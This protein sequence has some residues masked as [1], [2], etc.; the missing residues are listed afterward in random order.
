MLAPCFFAL[1]KRSQK[2]QINLCF[3]WRHPECLTWNQ[4]SRCWIYITKS[5]LQL[6]LC[7]CMTRDERSIQT[8][9][10][11]WVPSIKPNI[12]PEIFYNMFNFK[13]MFASKLYDKIFM[14][15]LCSSVN[16]HWQKFKPNVKYGKVH[17]QFKIPHWKYHFLL[18]W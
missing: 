8:Y 2:S 1:L 18:Y 16:F 4:K 10:P 17:R 7:S 5:S 3:S 13:T 14:Y 15:F 6:T 11:S 12:C 9:T